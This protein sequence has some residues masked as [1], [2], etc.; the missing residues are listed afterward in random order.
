MFFVCF[1]CYLF[2]IR[3]VGVRGW[4]QWTQTFTKRFQWLS[5][6]E[7]VFLY[8]FVYHLYSW[9]AWVRSSLSVR[10]I[11]ISP[12]FRPC[13]CDSLT[14]ISRSLN[15]GLTRTLRGVAPN[16]T[17]AH[18]NGS[19]EANTNEHKAELDT[20]CERVRACASDEGSAK[21]ERRAS[22]LLSGENKRFGF[23]FSLLRFLFF[24]YCVFIFS[25]VFFIVLFSS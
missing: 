5:L 11:I 18:T 8:I 20:K 9:A 16:K 13:Y 15:F 7:C 14:L 22:G 19:T 4:N 21:E 6:Y 10:L 17:T 12:S 23:N 1:A 25:R 24:F 2:F 3:F